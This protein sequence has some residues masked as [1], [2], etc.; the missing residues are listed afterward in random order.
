MFKKNIKSVIL[1]FA[2]A[3]A[4]VLLCGCTRYVIE[5]G[6]GNKSVFVTEN[7]DELGEAIVREPTATFPVT[8]AVARVR[9]PASYYKN[10]TRFFE[11]NYKF[12]YVRDVERN[13][14]FTQIEDMPLIIRLAP[15]N[16][17]LVPG[18]LSS[19]EDLRKAA[20]RLQTDMI[21]VYSIKTEFRD[22]DKS[23]SLSVVTLGLS[24]TLNVQA[25]STVSALVMDTNTGY[26]Y[27]TAEATAKQNKTAA[28]LTS[29]DAFEELRLIAER[30]A[31]EMFLE[32]FENVWKQIARQHKPSDLK[33]N[34]R[35][36]RL[37]Y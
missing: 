20:Q 5:D 9:E 32:Q 2:V 11:R 12:V 27:G 35:Y 22:S 14:D 24:P 26:I 36:S 18:E 8:M 31:F 33:S 17:L 34:G 19:D 4:V 7:I 15:L 6:V 28:H 37:A 29:K 23:S 30:Q 13:E 3:T 25:I 21:L 16:R 1:L 10:N